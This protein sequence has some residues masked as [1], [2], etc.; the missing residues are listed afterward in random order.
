MDQD[1]HVFRRQGFIVF[2]NAVPQEQLSELRH[3]CDALLAEP[4]DDGGG[5]RHRIGLGTARRFLAHRHAEFP[6]VEQFLLS[7]T[8][9]GRLS[10]TLASR[11]AYLFNE[12][13]VVKGAGTGASFAW[14]QDGAYVGFDHRAYVTVW[15]ALDDASVDNGCIWVL[16]RDLD[17]EP[18][19]DPHHWND[20][21]NDLSGYQ[22]DDPGQPIECP[23]GTMLVFS[24]LTLHRSGSN[25][26][27]RPRRAYVCQYS[28]APIRDPATG[29]LKRFAK[30]VPMD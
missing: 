23:A 1:H 17:A 3:A 28:A 29:A 26:T 24:S 6:A 13:F 19:L 16:P 14:H 25:T 2:E 12:Q 20:Q 22:G 18:R 21:T 27:E 15:I 5:T 10:P 11:E 7:P 9:A 4:V 8:V 30:P